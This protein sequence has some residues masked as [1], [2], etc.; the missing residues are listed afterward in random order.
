MLLYT[1]RIWL[2]KSSHHWNKHRV[3]NVRKKRLFPTYFIWVPNL[4]LSGVGQ[5][6]DISKTIRSIF[7]CSVSSV[8]LV[9]QALRMYH[10]NSPWAQGD[11][12]VYR[13]INTDQDGTRSFDRTCQKRGAETSRIRHISVF[14]WEAYA[15][16]PLGCYDCNQRVAQ[17]ISRTR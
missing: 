6:A 3:F 10:Q 9:I 1:S 2:W 12:A 5:K 11:M 17:W 8:A 13:S 14:L 7:P 15:E 4:A 16:K